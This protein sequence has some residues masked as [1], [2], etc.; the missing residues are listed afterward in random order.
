[1]ARGARDGAGR[2][3]DPDTHRRRRAR[4][5]GSLAARPGRPAE[6][7]AGGPGVAGGRVP[8]A[9]G[10]RA[11]MSDTLGG[12]APAARGP[13]AGL[14]ARA[15]SR[16][17]VALGPRGAEQRA[18]PLLRAVLAQ[19]RTELVLSPRRGESVL[20]PLGIPVV[21]LAFFMSVG[22]LPANIER[23]IDFLLPGPLALA[24]MATGLANLGIATAYERGD[25]VLKRLGATPLPRGGLVVGKL[26]A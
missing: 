13:H 16:P 24:V 25:G 14:A 10:T 5:A 6:R 23:R 8:A 11:T 20:V 9:H 2:I 3:H 12:P 18:A 17:A 15:P 7:A 1:R 4:R 22:A 19:A 21:L 26:L